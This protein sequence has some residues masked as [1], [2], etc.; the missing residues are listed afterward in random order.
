LPKH[1]PHI[2]NTG[3]VFAPDRHGRAAHH[4]RLP[5]YVTKPLPEMLAAEFGNREQL[6]TAGRTPRLLTRD[7]TDRVRRRVIELCLRAHDPES[8]R[9]TPPPDLY[10]GA[11]RLSRTARGS[12]PFFAGCAT[13]WDRTDAIALLHR[14]IGFEWRSGNNVLPLLPTSPDILVEACINALGKETG[15]A[16]LRNY[17]NAIE[18]RRFPEHRRL[19]HADLIDVLEV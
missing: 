3:S 10:R 4:R 16:L 5:A 6:A 17:A 13:V 18:S 11:L 1:S 2:I 12:E 15:R 14:L 7:D 8:R 19:T 9:A